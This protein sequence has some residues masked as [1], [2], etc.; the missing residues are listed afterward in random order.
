MNFI[1]SIPAWVWLLLLGCAVFIVA[2]LWFR[3][4]AKKPDDRSDSDW[5]NDQW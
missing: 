2:A 3:R 1:L 4:L 5:L